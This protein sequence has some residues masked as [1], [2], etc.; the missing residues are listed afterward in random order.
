MAFGF[1]VLRLPPDGFWAMTLLELSAAMRGIQGAA[2]S[3]PV[4]ERAE[5]E[6]LLRQ[7]P[8][9]ASE[10]SDERF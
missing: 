8:D 4:I 9:D 3:L 2:A 1:G 7:F 5:F 6:A 10:V